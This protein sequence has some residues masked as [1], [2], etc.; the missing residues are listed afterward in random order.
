MGTS[1]QGHVYEMRPIGRAYYPSFSDYDWAVVDVGVTTD[2]L[3]QQRRMSR[4]EYIDYRV[5]WFVDTM[6]SSRPV[7]AMTTRDRIEGI[8]SATPS[9]TTLPGQ[10]GPII[11][12]P[13]HLKE[14]L[15]G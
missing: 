13:V 14:P 12:H 4:D 1:K 6:E 8:L 15:G 11:M 9:L 3:P 5:G 10:L 2:G 7:Y